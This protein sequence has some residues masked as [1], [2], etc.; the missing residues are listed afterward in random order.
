VLMVK[1]T[2]TTRI[3]ILVDSSQLSKPS[4]WVKAAKA[5]MVVSSLNHSSAE[6]K[7]AEILPGIIGVTV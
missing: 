7:D 2:E 1:I 6:C 4:K 5:A 3:T